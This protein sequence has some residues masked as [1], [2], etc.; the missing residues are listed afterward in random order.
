V[1]G[2]PS[3]EDLSRLQVTTLQY[4]LH[5]ANPSNGLI[6]D[7]TDP[8]APCSIAAV[9][10]ALSTVPVL[11]ERGVI[12]REFAPELVLRRLRFFQNSPQGPQPDTTGY[13][14]FYYHFLDMKT[15]RRVWR[16]ELSTI[17]SSFL[18]AGML[19][20][21]AYFDGDSEEERELR[22][23]AEALYCRADWQWAM[24]GGA[25]LSHGWKPETGFLSDRWTGYDEGLLLYL[26]GLGSP[27]FPLPAESYAAYCSTYKWKTIY[28][29]ELLYSGPLFPHQLSHL[30]IDFRDLRD[31]FMREHGTDYFQNSRQATYVHQE[32]AKRNP[33]EFSGYGEYCW[34]ITATDGPGWEKRIVNGIKRQFYDY[35]A[36]GAPFGPDDGTLAPW[37][38]VASLPFAPEIVIP[39]VRAMA[40]LDLG[41]TKRY[42]FKPSFNQTYCVRTSPTGWWVTPYHFGVDQGPVILMIENYRTGLIWNIMRRS[43]HVLTGL[44]RAGFQGGWL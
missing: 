20:C 39:T 42:G 21:A 34:G 29:R 40:R 35:F 37:V 6:R 5:E 12:S 28:G 26:L 23:L 24:N 13:K 14:G 43:P 44:R 33:L 7:K 17:D 18:F 1:N 27:T 38:V 15:G 3:E 10:L 8:S 25:S 22:Q 2:L 9:G 16:C 4:Y 31:K 41:S 11:V 19:T 30:W 36:R 32:Y